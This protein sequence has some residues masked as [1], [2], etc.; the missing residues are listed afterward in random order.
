LRTHLQKSAES[1]QKVSLSFPK[2][3]RQFFDYIPKLVDI[4]SVKVFV[5]RRFNNLFQVACGLGDHFASTVAHLLPSCI[6]AVA[7]GILLSA[8]FFINNHPLSRNMAGDEK[9]R[10]S[11]LIIA[12][13]VA[14]VL[15]NS[16]CCKIP[17]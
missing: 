10:M 15:C 8:F 3:S 1:S 5:C 17:N 14:F 11:L 13:V 12:L 6:I 9:Y 4:Y 7:L 2:I 16:H